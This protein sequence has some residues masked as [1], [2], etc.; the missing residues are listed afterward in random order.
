MSRLLFDQSEDWLVG[1]H[2]PAA[3]AVSNAVTMKL[4]V[5]SVGPTVGS[6]TK[7]NRG[8]AVGGQEKKEVQA[9]AELV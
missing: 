1:L 2:L 7:H 8:W 9:Y 3:A 5:G 4:Q 6:A